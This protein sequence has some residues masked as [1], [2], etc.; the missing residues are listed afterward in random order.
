MTVLIIIPDD[1]RQVVYIHTQT[2]GFELGY[3][4]AIQ[5]F[6]FILDEILPRTMVDPEEK[7]ALDTVEDL[8][9]AALLLLWADEDSKRRRFLAAAAEEL[10][11][12]A[13]LLRRRLAE[14]EEKG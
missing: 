3:K 7:E 4:E 14:R 13:Q 12:T 5:T 9:R 6:L 1:E 2:G 10:E 11:K 8:V